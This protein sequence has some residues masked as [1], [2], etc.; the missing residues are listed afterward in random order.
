MSHAEMSLCPYPPDTATVLESTLTT[1]HNLKP[2]ARVSSSKLLLLN[3]F[4]IHNEKRSFFLCHIPKQL[5][6]FEV[7]AVL[8]V[9]KLLSGK[10]MEAWASNSGSASD[11]LGHNGSSHFPSWFHFLHLCDR[12]Y[13]ASMG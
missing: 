4:H 9:P 3:V 1:I 13:A 8:S 5:Q 12:G 11:K 10:D 6:V 2:Q 7:G